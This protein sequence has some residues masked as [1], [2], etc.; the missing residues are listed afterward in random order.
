ML[1]APE[2]AQPPDVHVTVNIDMSRELEAVP[3]TNEL[4]FSEA[5]TQRLR[6]LFRELLQM[7]RLA[8][9]HGVA[10]VDIIARAARDQHGID[11]RP[12]HDAR[13]L[14]PPIDGET[15]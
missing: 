3:E 12:D 6:V 13:P 2:K 9:K 11:I 14:R 7:D 8:R 5:D 1:Q 4:G 10:L 15:I